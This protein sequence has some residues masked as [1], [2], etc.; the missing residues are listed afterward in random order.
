MLT[1]IFIILYDDLVQQSSEGSFVTQGRQD[2]L[3]A[4]IGEKSTQVVFGLLGMV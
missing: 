2:I 1:Y 4:A 3:V